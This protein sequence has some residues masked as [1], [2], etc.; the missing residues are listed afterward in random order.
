MLAIDSALVF[1]AGVHDA[2]I[3]MAFD[4]KACMPYLHGPTS[5]T[6]SYLLATEAIQTSEQTLLFVV[7]LVLV[8]LCCLAHQKRQKQRPRDAARVRYDNKAG[9]EGTGSWAAQ[10]RGL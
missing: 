4:S 10:L 5:S 3:S 1:L 2:P 6:R 9:L 7:L 8:L